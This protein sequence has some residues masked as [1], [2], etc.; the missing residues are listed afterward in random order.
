MA[1]HANA[2]AAIA[3]AAVHERFVQGVPGVAWARSAWPPRS[4]GHPDAGGGAAWHYWWSAFLLDAAVAAATH[5]P[6]ARRRRFARAVLRGIRV[7]NGGLA[8]RSFWDDLA[9]LALAVERGGALLGHRRT[10]SRIAAR[11]TAAIDPQVGLIPWHVGSRLFNAPANAP[12]ALLL[13]RTGRVPEAV[14]VADRMHAALH[15]PDSGLLWDGIACDA[16]APAVVRD[17]YTYSQGVA[18]AVDAALARATG[19][20]R[21]LKRA[22][23]LVDAVDA[24]AGPAGVL[25]GHGGGDGGLF[26]GIAVRHLADAAQDMTD[27]AAAGIGGDAASRDARAAAAS[28]RDLVR[29]SAAAVWAGRDVSSGAT[30]FSADP[31]RPADAAS[32]AA[33]R[34]LSVQLGAWLTLEAAAVPAR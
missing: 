1:G 10:P 32:G 4:S 9:W 18:V 15:D 28:A 14:A 24:W 22:G 20:V 17:L 27:A 6:S 8:R 33:E 31:R 13:V 12:A 5:R 2:R 19:E 21:F 11:L 16:A 34:D 29:R 3:E 25:P 23:A 7:R 30:L 26:A